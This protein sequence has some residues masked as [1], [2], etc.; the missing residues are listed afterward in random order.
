ME[1]ERLT[2]LKRIFDAYRAEKGNTIPVLQ[3][4][5][6]E[7]GYLPEEAVNWIAEEL[8]IPQSTFFGAATFYAQFHLKPRGKNIVTACDGTA[9]HVKGSERLISGIRRELDL[10]E[11]EE[12][13]PDLSFTVEKV[14]CVGACSIAP[15]VV[16]NRKVYGKS[17]TDRIIK[18]IKGI[19]ISQG[20]VAGVGARSPSQGAVAGVGARSPSQGAVAPDK[21]RDEEE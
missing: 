5:E 3:A 21:K 7:F 19:H 6:E 18:E 15:V 11:G 16:I 13:T 12:T 1:E 8:D 14:N 9:C 10:G 20:A 17:T 2:A 4:I